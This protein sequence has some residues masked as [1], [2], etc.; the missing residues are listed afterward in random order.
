MSLDDY[1]K[2][3]EPK[4]DHFKTGMLA[5]SYIATTGMAG[6]YAS[7]KF[8]S[9]NKTVVALFAIGYGFVPAWCLIKSL[10]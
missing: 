9:G 2:Q 1:L 8:Y 7:N 10:S 4:I 5:I 6:M 3:H